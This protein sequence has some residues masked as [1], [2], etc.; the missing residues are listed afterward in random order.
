MTEEAN[1]SPPFPKIFDKNKL[2][3]YRAHTLCAACA[4]IETL[5]Q[6]SIIYAH[7][8]RAHGPID[9]C[10][11]RETCRAK[12]TI[13]DARGR[14]RTIRST[15][16][17]VFHWFQRIQT[18][19]KTDCFTTCACVWDN[20]WCLDSPKLAI[21]VPTTTLTITLP[22][23]HTCGVIMILSLWEKKFAGVSVSY[24]LFK[25]WALS[26]FARTTTHMLYKGL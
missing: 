24:W 4:L 19:D 1:P 12:C 16:R 14:C 13:C 17:P 15:L 22:L 3:H 21:F 7:V 10:A 2:E 11:S 25:A 8:Q 18:T 26:S 20:N 9:R 5:Q 23:V 6:A